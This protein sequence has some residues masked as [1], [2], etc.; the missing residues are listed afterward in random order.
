MNEFRIIRVATFTLVVLSCTA[1][2]RY[3]SA[4]PLLQNPNYVMAAT[5]GGQSVP[6]YAYAANNPIRYVDPNGLAP[7]DWFATPGAAA[8]DAF[9]WIAQ[10]QFAP[11]SSGEVGSFI[12]PVGSGLGPL[13]PNK[14]GFTYD[15]PRPLGGPSSGFL[16]EPSGGNACGDL[17]NHLGG[18]Y[19]SP[20]DL[21][22]FLTA[23]K[24]YGLP[25]VGFV[26][27]NGWQYWSAS[28]IRVP[29]APP[30]SIPDSALPRYFTPGGGWW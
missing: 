15:P 2:A 24:K 17:H 29:F 23:A 12:F 6:T 4:E 21:R 22:G 26:G 3:L 8:R 20:T 18:S 27:N 28:V 5:Q 19:P 30:S 13:E 1:S 25:Y 16:P 11:S 10:N 7:G 14:P 9:A